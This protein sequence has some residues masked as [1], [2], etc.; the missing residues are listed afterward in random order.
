MSDGFKVTSPKLGP[1]MG[2]CLPDYVEGV[3]T[4]ERIR[5]PYCEA[6]EGL[7][8]IVEY[9]RDLRRAWNCGACGS[10]WFSEHVRGAAR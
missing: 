3:D 9:E 5:C 6:E 1:C 10:R 7:P 8:L 4:L 2:V